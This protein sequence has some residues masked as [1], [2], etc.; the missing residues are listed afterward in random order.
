MKKKYKIFLI[1]FPIALVVVYILLIISPYFGSRHLDA[2]F[3]SN[4]ST[5]EFYSDSLSGEKVVMLDD[6][7]KAF[8]YRMQLIEDAQNEILLCSYDFYI[9]NTGSAVLGALV[10]KAKQG[11]KVSLILDGKTFAS[12]KKYIR[13]ISSYPNM[14][15]YLF[16]PYNFFAPHLTNMAMHDKFMV[17]DDNAFILGGR[18]VGDKYYS[19][20][21]LKSKYS[22]DREVLVLTEDN[23]GAIADVKGY[24]KEIISSKYT[25]KMN[26]GKLGEKKR[27][28]IEKELLSAYDNFMATYQRK[29]IALEGIPVNKITLVHNPLEH[30]NKE[31]R[32]AYTL[33]RL[34]SES[35]KTFIQTPY[36]TLTNKDKKIFNNLC[37]N[38]DVTM[39]TNSIATSP[40]F[41]GY[42]C[43]YNERKSYLNSGLKI[44]EFQ[45]EN[46]SIHAK[47]MFF[48]DSLSMIG[49]FNLD[50]R[51]IRINTESVLI[52]DS[53]EFF[54]D[55]MN[56]ISSYTSRSNRVG[57]N[58][59]YI[60][61][62]VPTSHAS[63]F[64][65]A[66]FRMMGVILQP[67]KML[68]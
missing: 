61:D 2:S 65:K 35:G 44:Y 54:G 26:N 39:L 49:S 53:E 30:L 25:K 9:D 19:Y 52:I 68:L 4:F 29:N 63:F 64:K 18:N 27:A 16:N 37:K 43:Y 41:F 1:S 40:N 58:N 31:P 62:G 24:F 51:S 46:Q 42:S 11:I 28:K 45:S 13:F 60:D 12:N 22:L 36:T 32:L 57:G 7:K 10:N 48:G 21:Y 34:A 50:E 47:S 56:L 20:P 55:N 59:K 66:F 17:V 14:E 67:I 3:V 33:Y 8:D 5:D 6:G 15:I 38:T 23:V